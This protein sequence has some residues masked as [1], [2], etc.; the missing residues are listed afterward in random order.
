MINTLSSRRRHGN[1]RMFAASAVSIALFL[2]GL[3]SCS[4]ASNDDDV[5]E[6]PQQPQASPVTTATDAET[7]ATYRPERTST[8]S[9]SPPANSGGNTSDSGETTSETTTADTSTESQPTPAGD[10][11]PSQDASYVF[12]DESIVIYLDSQSCLSLTEDVIQ[13]VDCIREPLT[14]HFSEYFP[15]GRNLRGAF[16]DAMSISFGYPPSTTGESDAAELVQVCTLEAG[17]AVSNYIDVSNADETL[18]LQ[19]SDL[20]IRIPCSM[21]AYSFP[22][23]PIGECRSAFSPEGICVTLAGT[24]AFGGWNPLEILNTCREIGAQLSQ[25]LS[26]AL[27]GIDGLAVDD[28]LDLLDDVLILDGEQ[29]T[30][31]NLDNP[32]QSVTL[33]PGETITFSG[34]GAETISLDTA[35]VEFSQPW[36]LE[37]VHEG[38]TD[39]SITG[40]DEAGNPTDWVLTAFGAYRGRHSFGFDAYAPH[41]F[42]QVTADGAWTIRLMDPSEPS[43]ASEISSASGTSF[44]G[45]GND[46]FRFRT[47]EQTRTLNFECENCDEII[48]LISIGDYDWEGARNPP[49]PLGGRDILQRKSGSAR[50]HQLPGNSRRPKRRR[51]RRIHPPRVA[52]PSPVG[53]GEQRKSG[54]CSRDNL[55]KCFDKTQ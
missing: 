19:I 11:Q 26:S 21:A 1:I 14:S 3:V 54:R 22:E 46:V 44:T 10:E 40:L 24:I 55:D 35:S 42:I 50:Q 9:D 23:L 39:F 37:A 15:P 48:A 36:I 31:L 28:V 4:S 30:Q 51:H 43:A 49:L 6:Q 12:C 20:A 33:T 53:G 45:I 27:F 2:P 25:S 34:E 18:I 29:S 41:A 16:S 7:R 5:F 32:D 17:E 8:T 47:G 38:S 52:H 13:Q